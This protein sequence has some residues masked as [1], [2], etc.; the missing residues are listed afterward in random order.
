MLENEYRV[1]W[2][3]GAAMGRRVDQYMDFSLVHV[4]TYPSTKTFFLAP[5]FAI[6]RVQRAPWI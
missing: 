5:L 6:L 3:K 2:Q 4:I 1:K